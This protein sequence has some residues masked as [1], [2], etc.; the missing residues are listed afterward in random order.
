MEL[1]WN[2]FLM[3]MEFY[4][5]VSKIRIAIVNFS[6]N[7]PNM[8]IPRIFLEISFSLCKRELLLIF[9]PKIPRN[10]PRNIYRNIHRNIPRNSRNI[11]CRGWGRWDYFNQPVKIT[12]WITGVMFSTDMVLESVFSWIKVST[13]LAFEFDLET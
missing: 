6:R 1:D 5:N 4:Q 13:N 12:G 7:I 8:F 2:G 9:P 11:I 10:I 3:A